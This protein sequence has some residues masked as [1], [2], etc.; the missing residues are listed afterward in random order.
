MGYGS[1]LAASTGSSGIITNGWAR[2]RRVRL[3]AGLVLLLGLP[4]IEVVAGVSPA[5]AQPPTVV[6]IE[7]FENELDPDET[8]PLE[9]YQGGPP[10]FN[11]TYT[12][13]PYWLSGAD[14]NGHIVPSQVPADIP[15]CGQNA[16]L[17]Q[18]AIRLGTVGGTP[19]N[20]ALAAHT[21][22]GNV[23]PPVDGVEFQT[24]GLPITMNAINRFLV[25]SVDVA[26]SN[27]QSNHPLLQFYLLDGST[28]NEVPAFT[29]PLDPCV[30]NTS[31]LQSGRYFSDLGVLNSSLN[32]GIRMR[33][34]QGN[35]QGNDHAIDNVTLLDATPDLAKVFSPAQ[36]TTGDI[37]AMT[38]TI[39]NTDELAAK[40]GWS[41]IDRLPA[42][43]TVANP[44]GAS[45]TC[46]NGIVT[47][48]AGATSVSVTGNLDQGQSS[49]TVTI[50]VTSNTAGTYNNGPRNLETVGLD[51]GP[52]A[53][54][55]F[56]DAGGIL[57]ICKV[58]GPGV[59]IGTNFRFTAGNTTTVVP[60]G[61]ARG[62]Y[63]RIAGTFPIGSNVTVD[64]II[65]T[66][67]TATKIAVT[68]IGRAVGKAN[69]SAG[70]MTVNIGSGVTEVT[71]TNKRTGFI[72][73]CKETAGRGVSGNFQFTVTGVAQ[74]ISVPVGACSPALEVPAGPT[75]V[76]ETLRAGTTLAMCPVALAPATVVS[77][78]LPAQS[79][80]VTVAAGDTSTQTILTFTNRSSRQTDPT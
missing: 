20:H 35:S 16:A 6:Y 52:P 23:P 66:G 28:A 59:P 14:C 54:V 21:N 5:G 25:F 76:T 48:P 31:A 44:A 37:T 73:I 40:P 50:S 57:K 15:E 1:A 36:L 38:F 56:T 58:A 42:G 43:L 12:A 53:S 68:P 8:L 61:P 63:C 79:A 27:C 17:Q 65:P 18:M 80:V 7:D 77:C 78:N 46:T 55:R 75:T 71:Y 4:V 24:D 72:E 19:D 41:F 29:N 60:A 62:G 10:A 47:A 34:G 51:P 67:T 22:R 49:C 64:E 69:L 26:V 45:T 13:D 70:T 74:P 2:S 33:N 11:A 3:A 39:T 9:D 30:T 32:L